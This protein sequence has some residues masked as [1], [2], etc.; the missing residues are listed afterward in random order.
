MQP[1]IPLLM[2]MLASYREKERTMAATAELVKTKVSKKIL[3]D[4]ILI[5]TTKF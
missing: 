5:S 2:D 3:V 4:L 1:R